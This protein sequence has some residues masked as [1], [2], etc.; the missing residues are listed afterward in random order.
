MLEEQSKVLGQQ[1]V[2]YMP[3]SYAAH[4]WSD[5]AKDMPELFVDTISAIVERCAAVEHI[6]ENVSRP[7][8]GSVNEIDYS[9]AGSGPAPVL[10]PLGL[11]P[12]QWEA[13][14]PVLAQSHTVVNVRGRHVGMV[15][16]LEAR[17]LDR[18]YGSAVQSLFDRLQI[19]PG[20]HILEVGT[21]S[22][23]L[24]R[25][26]AERTQRQNPITA[27]DINK[28]TLQDA[29]SIA[30]AEGLGSVIEF[31]EGNAE[32]LP[33]ED[34]AFDVAFS[35]TVIE[36]VDADRLLAEL[37]RVVRPGGRVGV[38]SRSTDL[39]QVWLID[40]PAELL[41]RL[42]TPIGGVGASEDGCADA[43]LY[44]RMR[45]AGLDDVEPHPYWGPMNPART[46]I[47]ATLLRIP[48]EDHSA[49]TKAIE[50]AAGRGWPMLGQPFHTAVGTKPA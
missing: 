1:A 26:L 7:A 37:K 38:I 36:E 41:S 8:T 20:Q 33:F 44:S 32:S 27:V 6:A 5:L 9:A 10:L 4:I 50:Q 23:A 29:E 14:V 35:A 22:G 11:A 43:S 30:T 49:F 15:S 45:A 13:I 12:T 18:G 24:V 19:T 48:A 40:A 2:H 16:T 34:D 42:N 28:Y 46:L 21:G 25:A 3:A 17:A 47:H 31:Q 39:P